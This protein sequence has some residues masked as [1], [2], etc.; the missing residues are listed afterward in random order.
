ME[1]NKIYQNFPLKITLSR[2]LDESKEQLVIE[3]VEDNEGN[4]KSSKYFKLNYQTLDNENGYW[5]DTCEFI[6]NAR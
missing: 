2:D 5:L 6:L 4:D 3:S 1:K